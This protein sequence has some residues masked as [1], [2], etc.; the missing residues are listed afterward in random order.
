MKRIIAA[1]ILVVLVGA[2]LWWLLAPAPA[3]MGQRPPTVVN[4]AL[5]IERSLFDRVEAVGTARAAQ[6]VMILTEVPGRVA[7]IHFRQGQKVEQ[8]KVLV[9]LDDRN[10]RAELARSEAEYQRALNDFQRGQKLV[11][12]R[13]ISQSE[14]DTFRTTLDGAK[15]SRDAARA[16]L[17]DHTIRAPFAGVVGLRLVD[18]GGYLQTGDAITTL[19]NLGY[20]EVDFQVP[21]RYL[22][23][24]VSG[25][26]VQ[27]RNEAFPDQ[28]FEGTITD[29]DSRVSTASR[30][31]TARARLENPQDRIR[32]GQFLRVSVQ[33]AERDALLVPEQS[34]ITQGAQSYVFTVTGDNTAERHPVTLGGRRDGWVEITSGLTG[35]PDVVVNGHSRLGSGQAVQVLD[36]PEALLPGQRALLEPASPDADQADSEAA[37]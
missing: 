32:P 36:N 23:R 11:K 13:A 10:A 20:I 17:N 18:A 33:L 7:Q 25:L 22:A 21:E 37:A 14:V 1:L 30:S 6:A 8:G 15:A 3:P 5:S 19:D 34:I 27:A 28:V 35:Q 9:T 31:L 24:L 2:G 26:P 4:L 12:S 29:L 16:N